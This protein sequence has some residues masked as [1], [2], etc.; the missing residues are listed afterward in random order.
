M[1]WLLVMLGTWHTLKDYLRIFNQRYH[2]AFLQDV[3]GTVFKSK[4]LQ[5]ILTVTQWSRSHFYVGLVMESCMRI[6]LEK[7]NQSLDPNVLAQLESAVQVR[8]VKNLC[9]YS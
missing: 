1:S 8:C 2:H 3:L 9:V 7:H 6:L 4:T 5:G